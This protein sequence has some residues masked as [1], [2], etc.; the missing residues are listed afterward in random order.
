MVL[1]N[2]LMTQEV[3]CTKEPY[4][5][6]NNVG[7]TADSV[8][9]SRA[10]TVTCWALCI[11]V[12]DCWV[13]GLVCNP[14]MLLKVRFTAVKLTSLQSCGS[15]YSDTGKLLKSGVHLSCQGFCMYFC[16]CGMPD[17]HS[18]DKQPI[19]HHSCHWQ[20]LEPTQSIYASHA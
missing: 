18:K 8:L 11:T 7:A 10:V 13:V 6:Q 19:H 12:L 9:H 14:V 1:A 15:L 2:Q 5:G 3:D 17:M 20:A 16:N 4:F